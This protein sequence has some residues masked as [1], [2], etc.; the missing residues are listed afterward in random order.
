MEVQC[1]VGKE[2][3]HAVLIVM[4]NT[5]EVRCSVGKEKLHHLTHADIQNTSLFNQ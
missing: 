2:K 5:K 1:S 3:L 4:T